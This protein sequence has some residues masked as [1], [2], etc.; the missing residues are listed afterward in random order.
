MGIF[1][2]GK[3]M[4]KVTQEF[5]LV[6]VFILL[7]MVGIENPTPTLGEIFKWKPILPF[8]MRMHVSNDKNIPVIQI[9]TFKEHIIVI[10]RSKLLD[11]MTSIQWLIQINWFISLI[12]LYLHDLFMRLM[13]FYSIFAHDQYKMTGWFMRWTRAYK[14]IRCDPCV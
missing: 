6:H 9:F 2:Y 13:V 8:Q 10:F 7:W 11:C 1:S 4:Q 5:L 3:P 12:N 14:Y